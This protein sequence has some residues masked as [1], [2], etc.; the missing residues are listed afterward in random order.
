[1]QAGMR[2]PVEDDT[3]LSASCIKRSRLVVHFCRRTENIQARK[4]LKL[5]KKISKRE[6]T[7]SR[8]GFEG[9]TQKFITPDRA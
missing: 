6:K 4:N 2:R 1:M 5:K 8:A 7:L 9:R 3:V